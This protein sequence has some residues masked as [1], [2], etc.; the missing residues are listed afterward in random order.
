M[1]N[2]HSNNLLRSAFSF[3][4][5]P[6]P[7]TEVGDALKQVFSEEYIEEVSRQCAP[8]NLI[9][10]IAIQQKLDSALLLEKVA[11]LLHLSLIH[12]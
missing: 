9:E 5:R 2:N 7:C 10:F 6:K 12:I 1:S 4:R 8:E 3:F 11:K